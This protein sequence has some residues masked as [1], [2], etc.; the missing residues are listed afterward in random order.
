MDNLV[1][2]NIIKYKYNSENL[3]LLAEIYNRNGVIPFVGAGMSACFHYKLWGDFLVSVCR[4]QEEI[5]EVK[6]MLNHY[7][8]EEAA[9]YLYALDRDNLKERLMHE[10]G[11]KEIDEE[12]MQESAV[13]MLPRIFNGPVITTNFDGVIEKAYERYGKTMSLVSNADLEELLFHLSKRDEF[14]FKIH[15]DVDYPETIIITKSKYESLYS[16]NDIF[17]EYFGYFVKTNT[18]LF[19]GCSLNQDR[20]VRLMNEILKKHNQNRHYAFMAS[21]AMAPDGLPIDNPE[22]LREEEEILERLDRFHITPIWFP[23]GEYG[24]IKELLYKLSN[25]AKLAFTERSLYLL[26][27]RY[28]NE[29]LPG[30]RNYIDLSINGGAALTMLLPQLTKDKRLVVLGEPGS[31]K[32]T[33]MMKFVLEMADFCKADPNAIIPVFVKL[34]E[35]K[36][37][38][39]KHFL[40]DVWE[41][42]YSM[43]TR[44]EDI[45]RAGQ[46]VLILDGLNEVGGKIDKKA[47]EIF[48]WLA[49][50]ESAYVIITCRIT[51]YNDINQNNKFKQHI[52]HIELKPMSVEQSIKF[53][54][55]YLNNDSEQFLSELSACEDEFSIYGVRNEMSMTNIFTQIRNT[56]FLLNCLI[57]Y[58]EREHK[59]SLNPYVIVEML[60]KLM[61]KRACIL[62]KFKDVNIQ[63][64]DLELADLAYK[65]VDGELGISIT[66]SQALRTVNGKTLEMA[67]YTELLEISGDIVKFKHQIW[68][69]YFVS[70]ALQTKSISDIVPAPPVHYMTYADKGSDPVCWSFYNKL[71]SR[72]Q[73][74]MLFLLGHHST[75]GQD[76]EKEILEIAKIDRFIAIRCLKSIRFLKPNTVKRI[77]HDLIDLSAGGIDEI[78]FLHELGPLIDTDELIEYVDPDSE[79]YDPTEAIIL[80]LAERTA[81]AQKISQTLIRLLEAERTRQVLPRTVRKTSCW[82]TSVTIRLTVRIYYTLGALADVEALWFLLP[83]LDNRSVSTVSGFANCRPVWV[84]A[85]CSSLR[86]ARRNPDKATDILVNYYYQTWLNHVEILL[87]LGMCQSH[88]PLDFYMNA[89]NDSS[90]DVRGTAMEVM[91]RKF[92]RD[93]RVVN[94]LK[95]AVNDKNT[96]SVNRT[97]TEDIEHLVDNYSHSKYFSY[98]S[99]GYSYPAKVKSISEEARK[100]LTEWGVVLE[101]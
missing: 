15:G 88:A 96:Y 44:L 65:M 70:I 6:K 45:I 71:P 31:G 52:P 38:N 57:D 43:S 73:I 58:Y 86:I 35:W 47:D 55:K 100:C 34:S 80:S 40:Q 19:L 69:E 84:Q 22:K 17:R 91:I 54:K 50:H 63:K 14:L 33:T 37:E 23:E 62:P 18:F 85:F 61:W 76:I 9:E 59:I 93:L 28:K 74:P 60:V 13:A 90:S 24:C 49:E 51:D 10:Y 25:P 3:T 56:P 36:E 39:F 21:P 7:E 79:K 11:S 8:Y 12:I 30:I 95:D 4:N 29:G 48:D 101:N 41:N 89:M 53:T 94:R 67:V 99:C 87:I 1:L 46:I 97:Y 77:V 68:L 75:Q 64:A 72:W 78:S 27:L 5:D 32:T 42:G 81:D 82:D 20:T 2:E 92:P 26:A 66:R 98:A 83:E 16:D